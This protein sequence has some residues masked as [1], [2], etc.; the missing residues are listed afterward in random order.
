[1]AD[2]NS[3]IRRVR[4]RVHDNVSQ[5]DDPN[6]PL[7]LDE[8]Y[9][10]ALDSAMGRINL[11]LDSSYIVATL[12]VK[13]EYLLELRGTINL[14]YV[15]GA[16][17][18]SGDVEDFPNVPDAIITVPQMTVQRQQMPLEGP[19][20]WLRL[21]EK[22]DAEYLNALARLADRGDEGAEIQQYVMTRTSLRTG[23]RTSYWAD[24]AITPTD[25]AASVFSGKVLLSWGSVVDEF[26]KI[27]EVERSASSSFDAS[28]VVFASSDNHDVEYIDSPSSGSWYY[29]LKIINSNDLESYSGVASV[30][31]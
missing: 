18:A 28:T 25:L 10:S 30:V 31:V 27:Y 24:K 20:Y 22:L 19:K 17:G 11:D 23:R 29:R 7:Y 16:E 3:M 26:F 14:C 2:I 21:A 1:M 13:Y 8:V 9:D 6:R 4:A 12:P 15:R 5:S